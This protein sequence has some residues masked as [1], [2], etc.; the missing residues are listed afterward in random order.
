MIKIIQKMIK[1]E[2]LTN[3][4]QLSF[5]DETLKSKR[6]DN[7]N[8]LIFAHLKL[9]SNRNKF[10]LLKER[11]KGNIETLMTSET[12]IDDIFPHSQF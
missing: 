8:K 5:C 2:T 1:I 10:E 4:E 9:N 11:I 12:K 7:V 6:N 3:L